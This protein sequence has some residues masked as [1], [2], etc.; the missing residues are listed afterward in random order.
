MI[1]LLLSIQTNG[2]LARMPQWSP[3]KEQTAKC[4][5][6]DQSKRS[7]TLTLVN[8]WSASDRRMVLYVQQDTTSL[9][10]SGD[11]LENEGLGYE[12]SDRKYGFYTS[13][14]RFDR[15][16]KRVGNR[17]I[18]VVIEGTGIASAKV[19]YLWR[20]YAKRYQDEASTVV[21][22]G[23]CKLFVG[24]ELRSF[25]NLPKREPYPQ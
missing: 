15:F 25:R 20:P 22:V 14:G 3:P 7:Q 19:R 4:V 16:S 2:E 24:E 9:L 11:W 8:R 23:T 18:Y 6:I 13:W 5:S 1:A 21:L 17:Y 10:R 12:G